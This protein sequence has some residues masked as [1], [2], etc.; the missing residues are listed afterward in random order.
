M[1]TTRI[2]DYNNIHSYFKYPHLPPC[3]VH[4]FQ[5]RRLRGLHVV[6]DVVRVKGVVMKLTFMDQ[7]E[8]LLGV[9]KIVIPDCPLDMEILH[10]R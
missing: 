6:I 7:E 5:L 1:P 2:G 9:M 8:F 10:L 3:S 4:D